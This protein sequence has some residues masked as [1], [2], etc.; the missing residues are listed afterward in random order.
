MFFRNRF[1]LVD[2]ALTA[3]FRRQLADAPLGAKTNLPGRDFQFPVLRLARV[4]RDSK[5]PLL[6]NRLCPLAALPDGALQL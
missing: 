6:I 4:D 1:T 5:Y 2:Q 3:H